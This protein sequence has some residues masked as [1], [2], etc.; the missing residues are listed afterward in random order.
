ML[1]LVNVSS[2]YSSLFA[3]AEC[4]KANEGKQ[5]DVVVPDK[6]SLY[7]EKFLF[8]TLNIESSFDLRVCTF[9]RFAKAN[10]TF[11]NAKTIDKIGCIMLVD[12]IMNENCQNLS[13]LTGKNYSFTY[14]ENIYNTLA[15]LK[16]SRI[17]PD[18]MM[19]FKCESEQLTNKI[20]D[21]GLIFEYYENG[22]A[23]L[24]DSMDMLSSSVFSICEKREGHKIIFAGFDDFTSIE[25]MLLEQLAKFEDVEVLNYSSKAVNKNIYHHEVS[26]QL[27]YIAY[28][29]GLK[30]DIYDFDESQL[31]GTK[32]FL[33][34]NLFAP[35]KQ[36]LVLTDAAIGSIEC[37]SV[38]DEIEFVARDIRKQILSG[39][40]FA[41]FGV[42]IF[43]LLNNRQVVEEIFSKYEINFYLDAQLTLN[44]SLLYK[45]LLSVLKFN[46]ENFNLCHI[47]DLI[48][49][50]FF[51]CDNEMK[52]SLILRLEAMNFCGK[53]VDKIQFGDDCEDA[54]LRLVQFL[55]ILK[56]ENSCCDFS[57]KFVEI[58]NKLFVAERLEELSFSA[59]LNHQILIKNSYEVILQVFSSIGK[60]YPNADLETVLDIFSHIGNIVKINNLPLSLDCVKIVDADNFAE[61]YNNLYMVNCNAELAP[62][63]KFD[64]GIILDDEIQKLNFA[65]KLSPTIAHINRLAKLR[66][67]NNA[68]LFNNSLTI[69]YSQSKSDLIK[70]LESKIYI[71]KDGE[72]I[73]IS[74]LYNTE[75]SHE[76]LSEKD[77][78]EYLCVSGKNNNNL[79]GEIISAKDLT[80]LNE[81][82]SKKYGDFKVVSP[83]F[84]E[85]YFK[86]PFYFFLNNSLKIK[87]REK[88]DL[89]SFDVGNIL[90]DILHEYYVRNKQVGD[91][92]NFVRDGVFAY[93]DKNDRLSLVK[94]SPL[95]ENL[96]DEAY[97]TLVG[98]DYIDN[99]SNFVPY[100]FEHEF[101]GKTAL[102]LNNCEVIGKVDRIDQCGEFLRIIDYK[103]GKAD[104]NL[105]EL[106]YGSKLQLFLYSCA[107]ENEMKKRVVGSFYL[108]LHN[109][110]EKAEEK[111]YSLKGFFENDEEI[112]L[113]FDSRLGENKSSDIVNVSLTNAGVARKSDKALDRIAFEKLK[114][115][116]K[117]VSE[118]AID[119]IRSGF[120]KPTP[121]KETEF[122]Q[123]CP[124]SQICLKDSKGVKY[125]KTKSVKQ[126]SFEEDTL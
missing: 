85:S 97:R 124:Y 9:D 28:T 63:L 58:C 13:V 72:E 67:F 37:T 106:Y 105:K 115:Y 96:I 20:H 94:N 48:N 114:N 112:L 12:R 38:K 89:Q 61:V 43:D 79:S 68:M 49:S 116:S 120:I 91:V 50:P 55:N 77:M 27:K 86:C 110:F 69:T 113:N 35:V 59:S 108:P 51:V 76:M 88:A 119:E 103:S 30:F 25:Y 122:C 65:H 52:R 74:G 82:N 10:C 53:N 1:K 26:D 121:S 123:Y 73:S 62:S 24:L 118:K 78:I 104:A 22:K 95:I 39:A 16:A 36:H 17:S 66:L 57:S 83:S 40:K 126:E 87:E 23:G 71:K 3:V 90:H 60:F 56:I 44:E 33:S 2:L 19:K 64:C 41:D 31:D 21:L 92:Y 45:F 109:N 101:W 98:M 7:M 84:L 117:K 75:F 32:L 99:N 107:V 29:N 34:Q 18:D 125:R 11:D 6:L 70:D 5:I 47:V 102:S 100:K 15:Q 93:L 54:K 4:C 81:S 80:N 111:V 46:L 8:E 42:A 14:A